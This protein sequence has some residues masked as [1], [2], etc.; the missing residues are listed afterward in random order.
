MKKVID[1]QIGSLKRTFAS[2][3]NA[4]K[5][6]KALKPVIEAAEGTATSRTRAGSRGSAM[7]RGPVR[8]PAL[9]PR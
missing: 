6:E 2:G 1:A 8:D 9:D 4:A 3:A 5:K 7:C